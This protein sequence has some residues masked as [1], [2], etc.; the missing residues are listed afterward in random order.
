M[1]LLKLDLCSYSR[2]VSLAREIINRW[3]GL[4]YTEGDAR[5]SKPKEVDF[6]GLMR[7][8][9]GNGIGYEIGV[10]EEEEEWS[11]QGR[12]QGRWSSSTG[13]SYY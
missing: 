7:E 5:G 10:K 12:P 4:S 9:E 3:I 6:D 13:S 1:Q 8:L 2:K 11:S